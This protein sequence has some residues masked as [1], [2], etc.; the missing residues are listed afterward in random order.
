MPSVKPVVGE[1]VK[2]TTEVES[3]GLNESETGPLRQEHTAMA[4]SF[5]SRHAMVNAHTLTNEAL[6]QL[7]EVQ[8]EDLQASAEELVS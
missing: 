6:L 8:M 1:E 3:E 4:L 5:Q 7:G 2:I